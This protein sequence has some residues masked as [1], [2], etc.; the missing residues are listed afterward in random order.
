[1]ITSGTKIVAAAL[2]VCLAGCATTRPAVSV[3]G[4]PVEIRPSNDR[5]RA[6]GELLA[7]GPTQLWVMERSGVREVPLANVD[8]VRVKRHE[9]NGKRAM[10][11]ALIGALVTG[12]ALTASCTSVEGA[13]CGSVAPSVA[14]T[15]LVLGGLSAVSLDGSSALRVNGPRFEALRPYAR[16]PQGLPEGLDP[17]A[18]PPAPEDP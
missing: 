10:I 16:F 1:M 13:S 3:L 9:W 2:S 4:R 5:E 14:G 18:L 6:K 7:V 17:K 8:Q 15:W 11:W 12:A